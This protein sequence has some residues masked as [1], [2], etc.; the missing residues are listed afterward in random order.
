MRK[1][2]AILAILVLGSFVAAGRAAADSTFYEISGLYGAGSSTALSNPGDSFLF[3]FKV[4]PATLAGSPLAS[5]SNVQITYTDTTASLSEALTGT[6]TFEPSIAGGLLDIDFAFGGDN[7]LFLISSP[8]NQQL[9][10]VTAGINSLP[11]TPPGGFAIAKDPGD[12]SLS[13]LG[14]AV[15]G[16]CTPIDSG[17]V[18]TT[19]TVPEPSSLL[20][21]VSS[22]LVM[23]PFARR[24]FA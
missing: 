21:L 19:A 9:Y 24:R 22:F 10:S 7:F 12:C 15:T 16:N 8:T 23:A 13:F 6:I 3:S 17:T 4:D 20:L 18:T 1:S 2:I 5:P 14:D 11:S